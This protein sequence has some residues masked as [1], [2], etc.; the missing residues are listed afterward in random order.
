MNG[1]AS[2][3]GGMTL[4]SWLALLLV[5]ILLIA[6]A[7]ALVRM[8]NPKGIEGGASSIVL[9]VLAVIGVL[10]LLGIGAMVLMHSGMGWMMGR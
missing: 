3:M 2:M 10:A 5:G 4:A 9:I 7:V 6:V 8:L 1:M